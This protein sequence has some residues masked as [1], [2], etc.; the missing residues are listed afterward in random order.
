MSAKLLG[1]ALGRAE[2]VTDR[3]LLEQ[4]TASAS[5]EHHFSNL[6][7]QIVTSPQFRNQRGRNTDADMT[8]NETSAKPPKG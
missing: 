6:V 8:L 3:P 4:M 5:S 1:Y 7:V 2:L